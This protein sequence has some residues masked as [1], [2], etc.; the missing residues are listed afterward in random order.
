MVWITIIRGFLRAT[1]VPFFSKLLAL[2]PKEVWFALLGI[3]AVWYYGHWKEDQGRLACQQEV[4]RAAQAERLRQQEIA[5]KAL[6]EASKR[7]QQAEDQAAA[8]RRIADDA[9]AE[10][11]KLKTASNVCLPR[12]VTDR[13]R[14]LQ[15]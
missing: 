2:V 15:R 10:A 1:A 13:V 7:A 9:V 5:R 12:N 11:Q 6:E 8:L 14:K 3:A 4:A